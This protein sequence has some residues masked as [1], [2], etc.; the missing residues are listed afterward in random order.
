MRVFRIER[1]KYLP[2][3]LKGIGAAL[4]EGFR[5]NSPLTFM[6]YTAESRALAMLEVSVHLDL[7]QDLPDDRLMVEI[8]I[9]DSVEVLQ[10]A[11]DNWPA[12]WNTH[13][14]GRQT[15]LIGDNF[16]SQGA[17]AV[18][19]VP[20]AIVSQEFNYLINPQHPEAREIR[21]I[22]SAPFKFDSRLSSRQ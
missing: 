7:S 1:K 10:L 20:S 14:P 17:A 18:L 13:P 4:S 5:W 16:V 12:E 22:T 2:D 6:V 19:R 8:D 11:S 21:V 9:P 3:T 15:Q